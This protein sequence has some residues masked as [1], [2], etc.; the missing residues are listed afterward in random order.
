MIELYWGF[1]KA[2]VWLDELP[3]WTYEVV[4]TVERH[5]EVINS[6]SV[7]RQSAAV[8]LFLPRGG[9]VLYGGLGAVFT[10]EDTHQLV[11]QVLVSIDDGKQYE[12]TLAHRVDDV[13]IGLPQ[14]YVEGVF[15]GVLQSDETQELDAGTLRFGCAVHGQVG[16]SRWIF[17]RLSRMVVKLLRMEQDDATEENLMLVL[18]L[19]PIQQ[20]HEPLP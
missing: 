14:E 19:K 13:H 10:P 3:N 8:E 11:A 16:S 5:Q 2:R 18:Q 20:G 15:E 17:Q 7:E 6:G 1:T 9:R 4:Q 12:E